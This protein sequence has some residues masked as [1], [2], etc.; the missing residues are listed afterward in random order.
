MG[1]EDELRFRTIGETG[2]GINLIDVICW[3]KGSDVPMLFSGRGAIGDGTFGGVSA[4]RRRLFALVGEDG[5]LSRITFS[6][7]GGGMAN[8]TSFNEGS[9]DSPSVT[10]R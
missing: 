5:G 8:S 4:I 6:R 7:R 9:F 10:S 2:G 1:V 3:L